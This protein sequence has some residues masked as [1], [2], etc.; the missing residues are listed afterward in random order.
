MGA[1]GASRQGSL[2]R[3]EV[4]LQVEMS[5][6]RASPSLLQHPSAESLREEASRFSQVSPP[7]LLD[8]EPAFPSAPS[9]V[10]L[11]LSSFFSVPHPFAASPLLLDTE[12]QRG[13]PAYRGHAAR[14]GM[15]QT[16]HGSLLLQPAG[17]FSKWKYCY[18]SCFSRVI[19]TLCKNKIICV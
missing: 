13:K 3:S 7:G 6:W 11:T 1:V 18:F 19:Q 8:G 9:T 2:T 14:W 17:S 16:S 5:L 15:V 4:V 10:W 12:V